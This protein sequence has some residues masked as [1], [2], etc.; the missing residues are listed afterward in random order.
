MD[1]TARNRSTKVNGAVRFL[2]YLMSENQRDVLSNNALY[3][4]YDNWPK[5]EKFRFQQGSLLLVFATLLKSV[6]KDVS[7]LRPRPMQLQMME[8]VE[9]EKVSI[10]P[11]SE[12]ALKL[13]YCIQLLL[14]PIA[15]WPEHNWV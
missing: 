6:A 7:V 4:F 9:Y 13:S 15:G 14:F 10:R 2:S 1:A 5:P 11:D 3:T 8:I 12:S